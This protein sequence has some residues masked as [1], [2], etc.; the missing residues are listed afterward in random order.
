MNFSQTS[1]QE[2][3][4]RF[5]A[6]LLLRILFCAQDTDIPSFCYTVLFIIS[7]VIRH[8]LLH[9]ILQDQEKVLPLSLANIARVSH[10]AL[11]E[12]SLGLK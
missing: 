5:C 6:L 11:I 7:N 3:K 10:V 2:L 1:C 9:E 12:D 8:Y 4:L